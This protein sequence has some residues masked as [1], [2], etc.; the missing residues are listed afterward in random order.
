MSASNKSNFVFK[1]Q[2]IDRL[3]SAYI[4]DHHD[5]DR[6]Q[7]KVFFSRLIAIYIDYYVLD[8]GLDMTALGSLCDCI[9]DLPDEEIVPYG[10]IAYLIYNGNWDIEA[11]SIKSFEDY[12]AY[13]YDIEDSQEEKHLQKVAKIFSKI[14][15]HIQLACH[16]KQYILKNIQEANTAVEAIQTSVE[17]AQRQVG[18]ALADAQEAKKVSHSFL[19]RLQGTT[20]AYVAILG[21]FTS[22]IIA[23]FGGVNLLNS[24]LS[25]LKDRDNFIFF[26]SAGMLCLLLIM[27]LL[28]LWVGHLKRELP[29]K[30]QWCDFIRPH[31]VFFLIISGLLIYMVFFKTPSVSTPKETEATNS[32]A[33]DYNPTAHYINLSNPN[34]Y[35]HDDTSN[36]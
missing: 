32:S 36:K 6:D 31:N 33:A 7:E 5:N 18:T 8:S 29:F 26:A 25:Y 17:S 35:I 30:S 10:L 4:K 27:Q 12:L 23:V 15:R 24:A 21:I 20:G 9:V 28:F 22:I 1:S 2:E 34:L 3:F 16:Q 13:R 14:I 19:E 11:S